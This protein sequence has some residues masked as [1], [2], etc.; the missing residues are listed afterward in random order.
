MKTKLQYLIV[1]AVILMTG[2]RETPTPV[3]SV[4]ETLLEF[5]AG[6][7]ESQTFDVTSNVKWNISGQ[8]AWLPVTPVT[9]QDNVTKVTVTARAN[10]N[11]EE[12]SCILTINA[13]GENVVPQTVTIIQNGAPH[14]S[15]FSPASAGFGSTVT[16]SGVNFG[17]TK[18]SNTVKFN[19]IA[20]TVTAA[21]S[22]QLKV[23]V[24]KDADCTGN[25]TVQAGSLTA[26]SAT[27][28]TYALTYTVSTLAGT[29][30][31]GDV[32]GKGAA[33]RFGL[34]FGIK[35]Y[36]NNLY[37]VEPWHSRMR[38]ITP[39][40]EVT[41]PFSNTNMASEVAFDGTSIY[42]SCLHSI[43]RILFSDPGNFIAFSGGFGSPGYVNSNNS[44]DVRFNG[45]E[46]MVMFG[47]Y[48]YIADSRNHCIRR[49]SSS[50]AVTTFAGAG[51]PA[52][53]GFT[54]GVA[55][56]RFNKPSSIA[57]DA[58]GYF[59]VSDDDNNAIRKIQ[60]PLG[61]VSTLATGIA[62]RLCVDSQG[63]VYVGTDKNIH[64]I[65]P[66]GATEVIAGSTETGYAEGVG[67]NARFT[68]IS[69]LAINSTD[70]I[71]YVSDCLNC[72]IRKIMIE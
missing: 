6:G 16:I 64:K 22:T 33:A 59:Y 70:N 45:P 69:G 63:N 39:D 53:S 11:P 67:T 14:I 71:L 15:S 46:S 9:Y 10:T 68:G 49:C 19:G 54:D 8:E 55:T 5:D 58:S 34:P 36:D 50:G 52:E 60:P 56:A 26:E 4:T 48:L 18:E 28:F 62:G 44:N 13:S 51:P 42:L 12:R 23:T 30:E 1:A 32:D 65:S 40:G 17:A 57:V 3:L 47:G 41:T 2:C 21:T 61:I 43:V 35:M 27:P 29:N 38:M 37:V 20:A 7:G 66:S 24:P 72:C 25:I 31:A